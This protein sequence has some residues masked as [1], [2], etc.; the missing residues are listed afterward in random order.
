[1][2][3]NAGAAGKHRLGNG[4]ESQRIELVDRRKKQ[5]DCR[6]DC[7]CTT[8]DA[9][10][11]LGV[12]ERSQNIYV[13]PRPES[14]H[15]VN[16]RESG[17]GASNATA[18]FLLLREQVNLHAFGQPTSSVSLSR[19]RFFLPRQPLR[20]RFF[21]T[22]SESL[23]YRIILFGTYEVLAGIPPF[24]LP[25]ED[26]LIQRTCLRLEETQFPLI[27]SGS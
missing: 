15:R 12:A 14:S 20:V 9:R 24:P 4:N 1:M 7:H 11:R 8:V 18:A 13:S 25:R 6:L 27:F 5:V 21:A 26:L 17:W 2:N 3:A 22:K 19:R 16:W 23:A 10:N